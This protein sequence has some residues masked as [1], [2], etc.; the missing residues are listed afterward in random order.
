MK[1]VFS[2][3]RPP[4]RLSTGGGGFLLPAHENTA[5]RSFCIRLSRWGGISSTEQVIFAEWF[6]QGGYLARFAAL[7]ML[8]EATA[9]ADSQRRF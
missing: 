5:S 3:F 6:G 8:V 1:I 2:V 9:A 4:P 7:A